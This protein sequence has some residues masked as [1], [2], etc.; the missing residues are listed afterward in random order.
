MRGA[1]IG[2]LVLAVAGSAQDLTHFEVAS[3]RPSPPRLSPGMVPAPKLEGG[4][5]TSD[6][7]Q[8]TYKEI[9]LGPLI[10]KAYGLEYFNQLPAFSG[11]ATLYDIV[12]KVPAGAT[13]EQLKL[14]LQNLL[15]ER[16]NLQVH[17]ES[18]VLPVYALKVG[19]NGP[20]FKE[21]SKAEAPEI[22][23]GTKI[24]APDDNGFPTLPP[25]FSG[26]VGWPSNGRIRWTGQ[27]VAMSK[28][29]QLLELDHP[30]VD[31]TGLTGEYDF[32]L[33]FAMAGRRNDASATPPVDDTADPAPSVFA[34]VEDQL[35][36][37]LEPTKLPFDV[38]VIDHIDKEPTAN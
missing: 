14:M 38:L 27:R 22:P 29:A 6:P 3:I 31:Q 32:Q 19:K 24:G 37:K 7:G 18:K 35:G 23:K 4:P 30:V 17:H 1:V 10:Y 36:L 15:V 28:L 16:F 21:S 26:I 8:I 33:D 5:G 9:Q 20:K 34:A 13:P 11:R 2:A 12:A 25:G